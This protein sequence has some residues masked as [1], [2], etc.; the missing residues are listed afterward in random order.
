MKGP[1]HE[2][3]AVKTH[4]RI[5]LL[6]QDFCATTH[7][8]LENPTVNFSL[9]EEFIGGNGEQL[10]GF[11]LKPSKVFKDSSV[12]GICRSVSS[13]ASYGYPKLNYSNGHCCRVRWQCRKIC[14]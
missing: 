8:V 12:S 11:D 6:F 2:N 13:S 9:L 10:P 1:W 14:L 3:C 4:L 7:R 5:M